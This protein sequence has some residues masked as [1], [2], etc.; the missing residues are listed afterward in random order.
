MRLGGMVSGFDITKRQING[1]VMQRLR[2]ILPGKPIRKRARYVRSLDHGIVREFAIQYDR[3][4]PAEGEQFCI[5]IDSL[6]ERVVSH[7]DIYRDREMFIQAQ[8]NPVNPYRP[9]KEFYTTDFFTDV[10]LDYI[11]Q[12]IIQK[13][14]FAIGPPRTQKR[15]A[16]DTRW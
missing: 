5:N 3:Y 12:A 13:K 6:P 11:N 7:F 1:V 14:E 9:D 8:E 4:R 15:R 2:E 16:A 10:A